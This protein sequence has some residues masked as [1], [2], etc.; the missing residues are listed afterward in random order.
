MDGTK[1]VPGDWQ[2]ERLAQ[3]ELDPVRARALEEKLGK[4][5]TAARLAALDESNREILARLPPEV[6]AA[7]VRRRAEEG[8]RRPGR[9]RLLMVLV[10]V[11]AAG[12]WAAVGSLPRHA[13]VVGGGSVEET[14]VKGVARL[15]AYRVSDGGARLTRLSGSARVR[16]HDTI[17]LAYTAG[18]SKFGMVLSVDGGGVVTQHLPLAGAAPA[19][20]AGT[21]EVRLPRSYELDDA[22]GFERFFLITASGAFSPSDVMDA[23][24]TLARNPADAR[25]KPL[26]LPADLTQESLLL[27]KVRP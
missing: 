25:R 12:A 1:K 4:E 11:V 27:E 8:R 20:L 2:L 10:P 23:A 21:G 26:T 19:A 14:R 6:V 22:P 13:A 5:E 7:S 17:Q 9:A 15:L 18:E 16:P 3:G 24:R